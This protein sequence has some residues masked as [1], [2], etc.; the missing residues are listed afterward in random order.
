MARF[1]A[2]A[3]G[4][5]IPDPPPGFATWEAFLE[6]IG[7]PDED[8]KTRSAIVDPDGNGPRIFFQKVPEPKTVKN[9]VH[10]DLRIGGGPQTPVAERKALIGAAVERLVALGATVGGPVEEYG[11]YCVVL[12]D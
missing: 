12:R 10:L 11:Q 3:L 7:V 8:R 4:Y 9:R 6:S 5:K 1:W 2:A